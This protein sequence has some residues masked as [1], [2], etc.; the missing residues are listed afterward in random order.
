MTT[1]V[2]NRIVA[3]TDVHSAFGNA[4]PMLTYLHVARRDSLVVDCGDFFEGSGYYRLAEGEIEREILT[5]LYDVVAPGNHGWAHHFEPALHRLTV[6]A[7]AVDATTGRPLFHPLH[8]AVIGGRRVGI[9]AVIGIQAFN[10]IP[11]EHRASHRVIDPVLALRELMLSHHHQVDDWVLLSHSGFSEDL[12]LAAACPFLGVIFSGHCHSPQ[13]GPVHIGDTTVL[14]GQELTAGYALARREATAWACHSANFPSSTST[15]FPPVLAPARAKIT[16]VERRLSARLG[17]IAKRYRNR[18][19]TRRELL[20]DLAVRLRSGLDAD[21]LVLNETAL[22][23]T[24]L[25]DHLTLGDLLA[26]EPFGNQ[27]VHARVPIAAQDAPERLLAHLT[28]RA[29]PLVSAPDP[30][31]PRLT[32]VLTTEYLADT[33]LHGRTHQAG[34]RLGQALQHL[35]TEGAER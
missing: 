27:L 28:E 14:K 5:G 23:P 13:H 19:P 16:D 11:I 2:L 34:L 3:T 21:V 35:L 12:G 4:A 29:G 24:P 33:C 25:G 22:R 30:L 9:T 7:N 26:I 10:A 20:T 6:C 15:P 1:R 32:T 8:V 17:S 31:P 18:L